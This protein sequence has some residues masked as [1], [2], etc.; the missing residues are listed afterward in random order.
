L[1][2]GGDT[3]TAVLTSVVAEEPPQRGPSDSDAQAPAYEERRSQRESHPEAD[4]SRAKTPPL[5]PEEEDFENQFELVKLVMHP[6]Q[7]E[8][9]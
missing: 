8:A 5:D 6:Q 7:P 3:V 4:E 1:R 2:D 9:V